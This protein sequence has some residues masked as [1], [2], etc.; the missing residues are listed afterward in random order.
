MS[1][2]GLH[3]ELIGR[4]AADLRPVTPLAPAWKRSAL[5]LA[6]ALWIGLLLSLFADF[7][8]LR[9]RLMAAPDMWISQAGAVFTAV[10]AVWAALQTSIPGRPAA[11][12][13]LPV[14]SALVWLGA[15]GAG[16][17]RAGPLA[18]AVPEAPMHPMVCLEFLVI[19]ALPLSGLLGWLLRRGFPPRPGLTA[20]LAGLASASASA[21]LLTMIHPF[22][23]TAEDLAAHLLAVLCTVLG[24][25]FWA[26][27]APRSS[28]AGTV[29][30]GR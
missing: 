13:L 20:T 10:L 28:R 19:V 6:A 16:C 3:G 2:A 29:S 18:G 30:L 14:P 24:T 7:P 27:R 17:L 21:A 25:W 15:S 5:W 9:L 11:W 8:A 26:G 23:A 12:G 22:D 1:D 4:L